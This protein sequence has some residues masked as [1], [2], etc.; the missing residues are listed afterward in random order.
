MNP[1]T[2]IKPFVVKN[3][4]DI[5]MWLGVS[6]FIAS[7][8]LTV[9]SSIRAYKNI[10]KRKEE[11]KTSH[12]PINEVV[13]CSWREALAPT[14]MIIGAVSCVITGNSIYSARNAALAA[15][16]TITETALQEYEEKTKLLSKE[17]AQAGNDGA[18]S[19]K[20]TN[21]IIPDKS[22]VRFKELLTGQVILSDWNSIQRAANELNAK[23][24]GGEDIITLNEW[25]ASIGADT[26]D[27]G[28]NVGWSVYK[29]GAR[30]LIEVELDSSIDND[31]EPIGV[32]RY[33]RGAED[34]S[35]R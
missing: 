28:D 10:Q 18:A 4:P 19:Q 3:A 7:V 29:S 34:L 23:A 5:L 35:T 33:R 1:L 30:G 15:A 32:I 13:K 8:P 9:R 11:L 21:V 24:I 20:Q 6:G 22:K 17:Q 26:V 12:L 27:Y 25:L 14:I 31:N 16:Y 2:L